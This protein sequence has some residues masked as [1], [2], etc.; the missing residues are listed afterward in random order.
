MIKNYLT[1]DIRLVDQLRTYRHALRKKHNGK[2]K[3]EVE[4]E[5]VQE[6]PPEITKKATKRAS[7]VAKAAPEPKGAR[8]ST[9]VKEPVVE[10]KPAVVD[11]PKEQ[12][13]DS[14]SKRANS[15]S[16]KDSVFEETDDEDF[17]CFLQHMKG[18]PLPRQLKDLVRDQWLLAGRDLKELEDKLISN[19]SAKKTGYQTL[20]AFKDYEAKSA[21]V[22]Q[23]EQDAA[24]ARA[25]SGRRR[26]KG[27]FP[28][29]LVK[30]PGE[31]FSQDMAWLQK[32]N[33]EAAEVERKYLERDHAL[34][35]KRRRQKVLQS[36]DLEEEL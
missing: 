17:T 8:R 35:E 29:S 14:T 19:A 36:A 25:R 2:K 15:Q 28:T 34:L 16:D 10:I 21:E 23:R 11:D 18:A 5:P 33:P 4:K 7:K 24:K 30:A 22:T 26:T 27:H 12:T 13:K 31:H 9:K 32:A 20:N 6:E 1:K 3:K